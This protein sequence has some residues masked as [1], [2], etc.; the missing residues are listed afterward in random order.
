M[1]INF[2]DSPTDGQTYADSGTGQTWTY[3]LATNSWTASSLAVTG[4]VVYKGS[5]DITAPPPTGAKA[6]EQWSVDPGGT[7]N[8]GYGP[9]VTGTIAKGSM[10]MYTGTDWLAPNTV[11]PD[12]TAAVKGIDTRK[13]TRTGTIL[14]PTNAGD[15]VNISAGTAAL[16]GLTPVGDADS[17]LF[18]PGPDQVAVATNGVGRLFVNASGRIGIGGS[19]ASA[20]LQIN[21]S[22][23]NI[24]TLFDDGVNAR[25]T[26]LG[27]TTKA[28]I[29][30]ATAGSA[31]LEDLELRSAQHIFS[32][33]GSIESA[34]IDQNGRLG[35][36]TSVPASTLTVQRNGSTVSSGLDTSTAL[37]LQSTGSA[38]SSTHL[39][40]L[41][42]STG[43]TGQSALT[44]G[45]ADDPDVGAIVYRH[46]DN[47]LAFNTN[48]TEQVRIDSGGLVGLGVQN[49]QV[50]LHLK[51]D[52]NP[53]L[54]FEQGD[55]T[56]QQQI[57][58]SG[59]LLV[60][61]SDV[62]NAGN[63]GFVFKDGVDE[64]ARLDASGRL[65]LG[66]SSSSAIATV[67]LQGNSSNT[68]SNSV[69]QL[70]RG[71]N[72][73]I[74]GSTLGSI[75]FSD[76]SH[77]SAA[78]IRAQS[79]GTW[80]S[81]SSQPT[82]LVLSTTAAGESTPT[83]RMRIDSAGNVMVGMTSTNY[84]AADSGILLQPNGVARFG[85]NGTSARNIVSFVNGTDGT[86]AEVGRIQTN[87]SATS[88]LTS[89]DYRLKENVISIS[90]GIT[91]LQQLKPSRF[92]FI[93]DSGK[94]VDGFIAH[95][96]QGVVPEAIDG[97]KDAVD[98]D[99][100]P[101]Y[102]GIDQSKLVPLLTAALQE[103]VAKI[104]SL[105]ARLTAAGL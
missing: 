79:D 105:E 16:P 23:S 2:P 89:S 102:Q 25:F 17:G 61:T 67:L 78:E 14:S 77:G 93:V 81:G 1:A 83:E 63:G 70:A 100:K 42:G 84:L 71:Q 28:T 74:S 73:F 99:G 96:V 58:S 97:E 90:D 86:P 48:A 45:D 4:G 8:A 91:R 85:G 87:G 54:R 11:I 39:N 20:P 22:A 72:T 59:G 33:S 94:A 57:E 3:E 15:V 36:G 56:V 37:S 31:A 64:R 10:V 95:E 65:L 53:R 38:G 12:A 19:P 66:T 46:T 69:L 27:D 60:F 103:A 101:V 104:E 40:I 47:S 76:N 88:Y 5:V 52:T 44:F 7:A 43:S 6:G 35:I 9:G 68:V 51:D 80:T 82:A 55:T 26:F 49:P 21:S 13:W 30:T 32:R 24:Y 50:N 18:S 29:A 98:A 92:N 62:N 75:T 41:A 34:R